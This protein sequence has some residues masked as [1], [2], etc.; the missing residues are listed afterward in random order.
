MCEATADLYGVELAKAL[1][2]PLADGQVTPPAGFT[3]T[4]L[5]RKGT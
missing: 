2:V 1:N 3:I 5:L 4:E